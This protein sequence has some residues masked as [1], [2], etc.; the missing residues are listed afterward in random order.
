MDGLMPGTIED[1]YKEYADDRRNKKRPDNVFKWWESQTDLHSMQQMTY[2]FLSIPAMSAETERVFSSTKLTISEKRSRLGAL[3]IE[4]IECSDRWMRAG[5]GT[6]VPAL[7]KY[8]DGTEINEEA[9]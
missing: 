9:L 6:T 8:L 1:E 7:Y 4:V 2:D 3:I 5:L